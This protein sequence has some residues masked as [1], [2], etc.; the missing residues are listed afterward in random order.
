VLS[1]VVGLG[2]APSKRLSADSLD[3]TIYPQYETL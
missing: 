2:A 1:S 3:K